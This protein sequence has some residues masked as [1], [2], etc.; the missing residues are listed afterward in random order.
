MIGSNT[1]VEAKGQRVRGRL[2]PWGIVEGE[3]WP[4]APPG[5]GGVGRL[6]GAGTHPP[7]AGAPQWRTRPTATS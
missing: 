6:P 3:F 2:Y 7:P 5:G 1:V 4:G